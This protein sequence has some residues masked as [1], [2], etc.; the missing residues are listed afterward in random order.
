MSLAT[1]V[2]YLLRD[3]GLQQ[4]FMEVLALQVHWGIRIIARLWKKGI[5]RL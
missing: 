3:A 4:A 1:P 2:P 5:A